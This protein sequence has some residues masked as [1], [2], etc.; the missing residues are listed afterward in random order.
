M[1]RS[2]KGLVAVVFSLGITFSI[3]P[4]LSNT[5]SQSTQTYAIA[6]TY[7]IAN[8][9]PGGGL[10]MPISDGSTGTSRLTNFDNSQ[11]N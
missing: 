4:E 3:Y 11:I 6:Q 7:S 2:F 9:K 10:R 8:T 1:E 5:R